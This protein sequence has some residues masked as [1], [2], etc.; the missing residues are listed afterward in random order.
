[1]PT[2]GDE[3]RPG[4]GRPSGAAARRRSETSSRRLGRL[5]GLHLLLLAGAAAPF[6]LAGALEIARGYRAASDDAVI[7][8]R[9]WQ[10]LS[11]HPPLVGQ[12]VLPTGHGPQAYDL[13]PALYWL[14]SV[15][16]HIDPAQGALWGA[17]LFGALAA[18]LCVEAAW[19]VRG[20]LGAAFALLGIA[21]LVAARP[22]LATD[23]VWNPD[24]GLIWLTAAAL[25]GWAVASGR[26]GWWPLQVVAASVAAQCH[27]IYAFT[28]A[29]LCLL[30]PLLGLIRT[31]RA[32]RWLGYGLAVG[33]LCWIP[34]AVQQL[35][36]REGNLSALLRESGRGTGRGAGFGWRLFAAAVEPPTLWQHGDRLSHLRWLLAQVGSRPGFLGPLLLA[37]LLAIGALAW[38]RRRFELAALSGVAVVA[39]LGVVVSFALVPRSDTLTLV[40][41]APAA[42]PAGLLAWAVI[43]WAA[44]LGLLAVLGSPRHARDDLGRTLPAAGRATITLA[45]LAVTVASLGPLA[46]DAAGGNYLVSGWRA[47][48]GTE[49]VVAAASCEMRRGPV[50]VEGELSAHPLQVYAVLTGTIWELYGDG[51]RPTTTPPFSTAF[52]Y[53]VASPARTDRLLTVPDPQ[54]PAG[55]GRASCRAG[56]PGPAR[57]RS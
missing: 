48:T 31:R 34:T 50:R 18:V 49:R 8:F 35:T 55:S 24:F 30:A 17:A 1:M 5:P 32:G 25:A 7:S 4:D 20:T 16:V 52:G 36:A 40:Y 47:I 33:V 13:G 41:L 6:L 22:L 15:P 44:G 19:S 51:W 9:A 28:A 43:C 57:A 42:F 39:G 45:A 2:R 26:T 53:S 38:W 29:A 56:V 37:V 46:A 12:Y 23:P 21:L 54:P 27:L 3:V 11:L 14:L 10:V